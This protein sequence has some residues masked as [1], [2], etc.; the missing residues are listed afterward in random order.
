MARFWLDGR[1]STRTLSPRATNWR[2]MWLPRKPAAPVTS[3]VMRLALL[4]QIAVA[5]I[6]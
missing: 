1:S 6:G 4:P 2:A 3:V 5:L